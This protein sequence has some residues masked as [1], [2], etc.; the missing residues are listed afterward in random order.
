VSRERRDFCSAFTFAFQLQLGCGHDDESALGALFSFCAL[1]CFALA[2]KH[3]EKRQ[4]WLAGRCTSDLSVQVS[5]TCHIA[6]FN[7][8]HVFSI[9]APR[10]Y[11]IESNGLA[12]GTVRSVD[13]HVGTAHARTPTLISSRRPV[14]FSAVHQALGIA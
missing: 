6:V 14:L 9:I 2:S 3:G 12:F 5:K 13:W 1:P 7:I 10:R 4:G 11:A 8:T